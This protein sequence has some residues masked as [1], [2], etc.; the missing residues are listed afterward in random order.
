MT[1]IYEIPL[2][3][4]IG[5]TDVN[6]MLASIGG[7]HVGSIVALESADAVEYAIRNGWVQTRTHYG[8]AYPKGVPA[9]ELTD[10]GIDQIRK[11]YG[12]RSAAQAEAV[13]RWY[14]DRVPRHPHP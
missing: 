14:R 4:W 10:A 11:S 7:W 12:P 1:T 13:R 9:Y 3:F 6:G 5:S 8:P 2:Q